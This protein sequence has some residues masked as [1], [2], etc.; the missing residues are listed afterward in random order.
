MEN[1]L[2]FLFEVTHLNGEGFN[3]AALAV[4]QSTFER[5]RPIR[6]KLMDICKDLG[7]S[8]YGS[9]SVRALGYAVLIQSVE[10]SGEVEEL[11]QSVPADESA[12]PITKEQFEMIEQSAGAY[13]SDC[14][15]F[16]VSASQVRWTGYPR[17]GEG[18]VESK[19]SFEDLVFSENAAGVMTTG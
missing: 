9:V 11:L 14:G 6:G 2:Y 7:E 16:C 15:G 19:A 10:S 4:S 12:L 18:L 3:Y 8:V 13:R 17:H 5:L 1:D